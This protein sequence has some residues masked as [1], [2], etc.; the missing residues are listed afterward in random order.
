M[1]RWSPVARAVIPTV[2]P[3]G[4]KLER[5]RKLVVED[6]PQFFRISLQH[7]VLDMGCNAQGPRPQRE[8]PIVQHTRHDAPHLNCFQAQRAA[9]KFG[10]AKGQQ[11]FDQA[12][13]LNAVAAQDAKTSC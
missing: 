2:P 8:V 13:Q 10:R 4:G 5:V 1:T 7:D 9:M 11:V 6:D 12:L 3:P